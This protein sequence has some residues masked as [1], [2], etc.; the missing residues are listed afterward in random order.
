MM[1][2]KRPQPAVAEPGPSSAVWVESNEASSVTSAAKPVS[3]SC[4]AVDIQIFLGRIKVLAETIDSEI[5]AVSWPDAKQRDAIN[6]VSIFAAIV[7]DQVARLMDMAEVIE[8]E[9][10]K[11]E[12]A[13]K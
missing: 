1:E 10:T 12:R 2:N 3:I 9:A 4:Q 8:I 13:G 5:D 7:A 6:R 11:Q